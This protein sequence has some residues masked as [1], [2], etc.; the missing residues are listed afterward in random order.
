MA[1][2]TVAEPAEASAIPD[3]PARERTALLSPPPAHFAKK[4]AKNLHHKK[5]GTTLY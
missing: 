1:D 2:L 5:Y 4:K 3:A